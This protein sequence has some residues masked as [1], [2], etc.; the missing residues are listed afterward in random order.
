MSERLERLIRLAQKTGDRLIVHDPASD[1]D[2]VLMSIDEYE[3]FFD[4]HINE[5]SQQATFVG[6]LTEQELIG[7]INAEIAEWREGKS[8]QQTEEFE[9]R[10]IEEI[11]HTPSLDPFAE[12]FTHDTSW[13]HVGDV[14]REEYGST[15]QNSEE[16]PPFHN[17]DDE[18][19]AE[20]IGVAEEEGEP[21]EREPE[22]EIRYEVPVE[23][24]SVE[25]TW[26][27]HNMNRFAT[28]EQRMPIPERTDE[29]T[30]AFGPE[31]DVEGGPV[32]L[33][34]PV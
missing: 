13:H 25:A 5:Q 21:E 15:E 17:E 3:H 4:D 28:P 31:K 26:A 18:A 2:V 24:S 8:A 27:A 14:M 10:L 1:T 11:I 22:E 23:P 7:R 6:D 16:K 32:F 29:E 9:E 12:D 19:Y 34:E 20:V 33:E 30:P